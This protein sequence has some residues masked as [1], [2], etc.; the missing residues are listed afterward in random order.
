[1]LKSFV[2]LSVALF[3]FQA[4]AQKNSVSTVPNYDNVKTQSDLVKNGLKTYYP[5]L[6]ANIADN[7][8]KISG[9]N[10]FPKYVKAFEKNPESSP[11]SMFN[12]NAHRRF[13]SKEWSLPIYN[14]GSD[15]SEVIKSEFGFCAGFTAALRKLNMMAFFDPSNSTAQK[16]PVT[17]A[18]K[19]AFYQTKID[20]MMSN[21]MTVIPGYNNVYEFVSDPTLSLHFKKHIVKQWENININVLQ[22]AIG[23]MGSTKKKPT[24]KDMQKVQQNLFKKVSYGYNPIVYLSKYNDQFLNSKVWQENAKKSYANFKDVFKFA[25][26]ESKEVNETLSAF[27]EF[28]E[29]LKKTLQPDTSHFWIHVLQVYEVSP[30]DKDGSFY[31]KVWDINYPAANA[32]KRITVTKDAKIYMGMDYDYDDDYVYLA[33]KTIPKTENILRILDSRGVELNNILPLLWDDLEI[34][35]MIQSNIEFCKKNNC[36]QKIK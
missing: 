2:I 20:E 1:M 34:E 8:L 32:A 36:T 9:L 5:E 30:L 3:V 19:I 10:Q 17:P 15:L 14:N 6:K 25:I 12:A 24:L 11:F 18:E 27:G 23:G 33:N 21:R 7:L 35:H 28:A 22:G 13:P 31:F 26:K 4:R 29:D 16:I